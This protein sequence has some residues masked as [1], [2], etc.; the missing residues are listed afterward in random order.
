M[1]F[2]VTIVLLWF[3]ISNFTTII[4]DIVNLFKTL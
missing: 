3:L 1:L 2:V 4:N